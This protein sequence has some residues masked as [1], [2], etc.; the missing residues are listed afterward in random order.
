[1]ESI[2][3][4]ISIGNVS[5]N[6]TKLEEFKVANPDYAASHYLCYSND[7]KGWRIYDSLMNGYKQSTKKY[8]LPNTSNSSYPQAVLA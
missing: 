6:I 3:K 7:L 8:P 4:T 5:F 1:M 2:M